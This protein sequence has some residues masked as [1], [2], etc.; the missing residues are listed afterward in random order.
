MTTSD[1]DTLY[2][3]ALGNEYTLNSS[4]LREILSL[5]NN[6]PSID[7]I[8]HDLDEI[9]KRFIRKQETCSIYRNPK[10]SAH[11]FFNPKHCVLH[12]L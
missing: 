9:C 2:F 4:Q 1:K 8:D 12:Y 11:E 3:R 7:D 5:S 10:P 6:V